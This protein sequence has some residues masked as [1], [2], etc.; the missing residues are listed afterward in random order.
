MSASYCWSI[1]DGSTFVL[2][3]HDGCR[4][5][6]EVIAAMGAISQESNEWPWL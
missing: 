2:Q 5:G 3:E 6:A 1:L 4:G